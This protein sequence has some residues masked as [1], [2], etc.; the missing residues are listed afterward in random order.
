MKLCFIAPA[1]HYHKKKWHEWFCDRN[2][3]IHV[4]FSFASE[5][6]SAVIVPLS[7]ALV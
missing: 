2:R 4:L 6:G 7:A 3:E 5:I 1:D